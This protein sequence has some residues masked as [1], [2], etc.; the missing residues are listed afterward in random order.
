MD[1]LD[2]IRSGAQQAPEEVAATPETEED[3]LII[4]EDGPVDLG[5]VELPN[6]SESRPK[7]H[8]I[9]ARIRNVG[10]ALVLM[11]AV[12]AITAKVVSKQKRKEMLREKAEAKKARREKK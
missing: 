10:M 5:Y 9:R 2:R 8:G 12:G 1:E 3:Y 6:I 11:S 4:A 7:W